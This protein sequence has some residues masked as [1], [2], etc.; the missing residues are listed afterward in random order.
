M[1]RWEYGLFACVVFFM[2][3]MFG[4]ALTRKSNTIAR[5]QAEMDS[6]AAGWVDCRVELRNTGERVEVVRVVGETKTVYY[7][8]GW[9]LD[10]TKSGDWLNRPCFPDTLKYKPMKRGE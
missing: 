8:R 10:S 7:S 9:V 5:Q 1:K 4:I 6:C 2:S 3:L